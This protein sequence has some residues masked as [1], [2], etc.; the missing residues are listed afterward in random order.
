MENNLKE[1]S[2]CIV[3]PEQHYDSPVELLKDVQR[4]KNKEGGLYNQHPEFMPP[5]NKF[6]Q[7]LS[8]K[9][10][11]LLP[12]TSDYNVLYRGQRSYAPLCLP[13]LYR[14]E[15]SEKE[16]FIERLRTV[17]FEL[18]IRNF[19]I[20]KRFIKQRFIV[21][22]MGLAQHY[23]LLTDV[24]DLTCDIR[25]ALFFAMCE[26]D[27]VI[28]CYK[29]QDKEGEYIGYVYAMMPIENN[30]FENVPKVFATVFSE[31]VKCIGL[32]PF[33]RPGLQKG[34]GLHYNSS[35][36]NFHGYLYSFSFTKKDSEDIFNY[37]K[38]GKMLLCKDDIVDYTKAIKDSKSFSRKALHLAVQ[39]YG[40]EKSCRIWEK[41]IKELGYKIVSEKKLVWKVRDIHCSEQKWQEL[42]SL[43]HKSPCVWGDNKT[44][45]M[46]TDIL[47][48]SMF[49]ELLNSGLDAPK[50]YDSGICITQDDDKQ[51]F[52]I[53]TNLN[54]APSIPD[55]KDKKIHSKWK[56]M[57]SPVPTKCSI[58]LPDALKPHLIYVPNS[59]S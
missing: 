13:T 52:G 42:L 56:E 25:V 22:Y 10:I 32:Q 5:D 23:G 36:D 4:Y 37:F 11:M 21:D 17:E 54:H 14:R 48:C 27:T 58:K 12:I 18:M 45:I 7:V 50:G 55:K 24:L 51:I 3:P 53:Q 19:E 34:F 15:Y 1:N 39:R 47:G 44:D 59:H 2:I 41:K 46:T 33:K 26:Y 38:N 57:G 6:E 29:P 8:P 16:L 31:K 9:G 28:D 43:L 49:L 35:K 30:T 40:N 20:T